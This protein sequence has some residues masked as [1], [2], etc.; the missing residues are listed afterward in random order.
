MVDRENQVGSGFMGSGFMGS[1]FMGS[2]FRVQGSGF[3]GSGFRRFKG[4]GGSRVHGSDFNLQRFASRRFVFGAERSVPTEP[5]P[6]P[7]TTGEPMNP[8]PMNPEP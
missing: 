3:M 6:N 4:S 8:E 1:G 7:R 2:G 5:E